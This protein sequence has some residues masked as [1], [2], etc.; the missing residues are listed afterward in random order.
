MNCSRAGVNV[1]RSTPAT[2]FPVSCGVEC[3]NNGS[4]LDVNTNYQTI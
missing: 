3:K 1:L 4:G 2:A